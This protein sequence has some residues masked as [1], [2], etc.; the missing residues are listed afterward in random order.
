ML[1]KKKDNAESSKAKNALFA[2]KSKIVADDE[3]AV[4]PTAKNET[5][6]REVKSL[7]TTVAGGKV[8]SHILKNPRIT[9][10]ASVVASHNVYVFDVART[11]NKIEIKA[12]M[13]DVYK[14][15][16]V[17]VHIVTVPAKTSTNRRGKTTSSG[18]GKKAYVFLKKG[19]TI[20]LI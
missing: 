8:G 5:K 12:A 19:D 9:E 10:K 18:V 17:K 3:G 14:V 6:S 20:E 15:S 11:A 2:R 1:F 4:K 16:P 7:K 13:K